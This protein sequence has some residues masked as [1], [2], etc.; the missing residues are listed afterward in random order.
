MKIWGGFYQISRKS[1]TDLKL[2]RKKS[3]QNIKWLVNRVR[4]LKLVTTE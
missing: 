4:R 2:D 1:L 3:E